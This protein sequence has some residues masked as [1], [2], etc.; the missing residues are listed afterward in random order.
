MCRPCKK[1]VSLKIE[2]EQ[3]TLGIKF[4]PFEA[5]LIFFSGKFGVLKRRFKCLK[6]GSDA[7]KVI[8]QAWEPFCCEA[9]LTLT[10]TY[11]L[12]YHSFRL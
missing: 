11:P 1:Y 10:P 9:C 12:C 7:N 3:N 2:R 4:F 6:V 5:R 8:R